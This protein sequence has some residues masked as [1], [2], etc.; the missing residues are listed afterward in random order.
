MI[1]V[2]LIG[3]S[4]CCLSIGLWN[5][6]WT[7]ILASVALLVLFPLMGKDAS[8]RRKLDDLWDDDDLSNSA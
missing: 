3:A 8:R 5:H 7:T 4:L 2:V 6:D 1:G